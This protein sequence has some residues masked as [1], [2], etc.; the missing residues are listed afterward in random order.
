[1]KAPLLE[2]TVLAQDDREDNNVSSSSQDYNQPAVVVVDQEEE[3]SQQLLSSS[4]QPLEPGVV[5]D[6]DVEAD[7]PPSSALAA[8]QWGLYCGICD[9]RLY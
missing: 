3:K 5:R 2:T 6:V 8:R 1:M 4:Q 7:N 9:Y